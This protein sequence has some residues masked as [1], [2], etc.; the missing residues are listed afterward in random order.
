MKA[1]FT[2]YIPP[3]QQFA[4][5]CD[6]AAIGIAVAPDRCTLHFGD[7]FLDGFKLNHCFHFNNI[8]LTVWNKG[9]LYSA[10]IYIVQYLTDGYKLLLVNSSHC[11]FP[12]PE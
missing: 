4:P 1:S 12:G 9:M 10:N 3:V 11:C 7:D 8:N 6:A 5:V 2:G